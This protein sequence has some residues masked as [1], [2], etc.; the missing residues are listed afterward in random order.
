MRFVLIV[1]NVF[2]HDCVACTGTKI[3]NKPVQENPIGFSEVKGTSN[4]LCAL[5][6]TVQSVGYKVH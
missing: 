5:L 2:V 4:E 1:G 3:V 6:A